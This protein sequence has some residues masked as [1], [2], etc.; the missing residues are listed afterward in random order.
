MILVS[1]HIANDLNVGDK[2]IVNDNKN[3]IFLSIFLNLNNKHLKKIN[4][5]SKEMLRCINLIHSK[6]RPILNR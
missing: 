1:G 4:N 3:N 5:K 2:K 6:D